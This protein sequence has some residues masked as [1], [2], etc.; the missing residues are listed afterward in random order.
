MMDRTLARFC[1]TLLAATWLLEAGALYIFHSVEA[2]GIRLWLAAAMFLPS[3]WTAAFLISHP[4]FR[5]TVMWRIGNP[6]LW[7][8]GI[9]VQIA[10]TFAVV[11]AV[12]VFGWGHSGWF[13]FSSS[14]VTISGG[15]WLL[16][17]GRQSW[18]LF[19]ANVLVTGIAYSSLSGF[20]TVGEEFCWRGFLQNQLIKRFGM[21]KV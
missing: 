2:P 14:E 3:V 1:G 15:P 6:W 19:I 18:A 11:F 17:I 21:S 16:G 5:K 20:F 12:L 13:H 4:A 7:P 9:L 10:S 8:L